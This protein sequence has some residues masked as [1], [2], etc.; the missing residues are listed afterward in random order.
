MYTDQGKKSMPGFGYR[1]KQL[2]MKQMQSVTFSERL[3]LV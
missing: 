1:K 2:I 3:E